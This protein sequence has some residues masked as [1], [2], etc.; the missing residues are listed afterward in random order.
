MSKRPQTATG[1]MSRL[2]R[3]ADRL[4]DLPIWSKLGLIMLVPT[5]ATIIVGVS[6]LVDH[7]EEAN[8][9]ERA[10]TL[11]VLSE[12][13][14][15]LVDHLQNERA[16]GMMITTI[17]DTKSPDYTKAKE[18]YSAENALVDAAKAPYS[19]QKAALDDVPENVSTLLLRLDRNLEELPAQR[20][21]IANN[22]PGTEQVVEESYTKLIDDLL[23]VRDAAAQLASDTELSD[24]LR[25]VAAVARAKEYIAQQRD[26]GHEILGEGQ[27]TEQLRRDFLLAD[28]GFELAGTTLH[29][30]GLAPDVTAFD[31][32]QNLPAGRAAT[33]Y[34]GQL[35]RLQGANVRNIPFNTANWEQ[36]MTGYN[37]EFRTVESRIDSEIVAQATDL[38]NDV[39]RRVFLETSILLGMLLLAILFAWLV[40]RS[41]ARSLRELRQGALSV[42]QFG[43]PHAVSRL[44]DPQLSTSLTPAQLADQI[45]EPLPVRSRDEF[46]QVTEAFNAVHLEAVRTAAEQAALRASVATMFV[47]LARRSQILVDRLIGHLDRLERGEEDPDRLA[48]LFQ[49]DH[50]ATRMRRND[51][52][53]LVLAGADSTR[54]QREPAALIDVLRAAQSE[55]EHYT[56]IEFGMI[57]RDIEVAAHAVN[58]MVHLVAELFDNATAFSPPNSTVI[59]EARRLG[60]DALLSV[61]DRGIG[62]SRE[63]L[64]ELNE[65]LAN[66]PMVDVAVSRMMGLVVVARLANRHGVK[67]ELRP[68]DT[69]RGTVAEVGLPLSVL[70]PSQ[71][72]NVLPGGRAQLGAGYDE[73]G[74]P[75]MPEPLAL[76]SGRGGY[77]SGSY[78]TGRPFDPNPPMNSGGMLGTNGRSVP[79]WSDLTGASSNGF[80]A[81]GSLNGGN[82]NGNGSNGSNGFYGPRSNE[83][84][85]PL[86]SGPGGPPSSPQGFSTAPDGLPQRRNGDQGR[87]D[88]DANGFGATIPRQLPANP[89]IQGRNPYVPPVSAPPV[90]PVSAPPVPSGPPYGGRPTSSPTGS[91]PPVSAPPT[92]AQSFAPPVWPPVAPE[93]DNPAPHV[94]ESLAAA[95]DMTAELPRYRPE[96]RG[97]QRP[98]VERPTN[99]QTAPIPASAPPASPV[100]AAP[101]SGGPQTEAERAESQRASAAARAAHE[102]ATAQAAEAQATAA[103]QIAAAQAARQRDNNQGQFADETMELPI[104]RELESAWFTTARPADAKPSANGLDEPVSSQ[105]IPT[106]EPSRSIGVPQQAVSPE[107]R[108]RDP[109]TVGV[110]AANGAGSNGISSNGISSNGISSNGNSSNG[111]VATNPWQTAADTGWQAAQAAAEVAV[112]TTTTAGLPKRTPMAQLVPGGVDREDRSVQRRTPEGVRGLLS[113]YHRGV[114][115]GRTKESTNPEETPGGQ[116]SSQAGKEHEA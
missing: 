58:D 38:R 24:H 45:A 108:D 57:D 90:P 26:I 99:P 69:E 105:R 36:A 55:V 112:D 54:V 94:P 67:V 66:P 76:E 88:G 74:R 96:Q 110:G 61:E 19:Q 47:N 60:D 13:A 93:R 22:R 65:R 82:G 56:R 79:A 48:E 92:G 81:N 31:R 77:P 2:R 27:L 103:A 1:V 102:A 8:N 44:R 104:F 29:S 107:S 40:A 87:P 85:P 35:D 18:Q 98:Q 39:N 7:I 3:P 9:A 6:G 41:M 4:R 15:G 78:P 115:R 63:Q 43:L 59:V 72:Q 111:S 97:D 42:A 109:A 14:G 106:G 68:A 80:G 12:A 30:V 10:R 11:S 64:R 33:N 34:T 21:Q 28:T 62:I 32:I 95:L 100:S 71:G 114:Q 84:I 73:Q 116:Q 70:T 46:G 101:T 91:E 50:L 37:D 89:E 52:N 83:A 16:Y 23:G 20:S 17:K 25:S 86:P 49:L 5:L 53:L 51:E 113:A 75:G